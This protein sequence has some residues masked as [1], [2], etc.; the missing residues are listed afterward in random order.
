MKTIGLI[1]GMS[2]ESTK[3]YYELINKRTKDLLGGSHSAKILL[4]SVDFAEI[5]RLTFAGDWETIGDLMEQAAIQLEKGGADFILLCTNTIHMVKDRIE[6]ASPL[7][8]VHIAEAVGEEIVKSS[9]RHIGLLGTRF[10]MEMDF[11]TRTL[12]E[13]FGIRTIVPIKEDRETL[14][15]V[16]YDELVKGEIDNKSRIKCASII[17][18]L[19]RQGA[20]GIILGCTELPL[21]LD[22][23]DASVALFDTTKIHAHKAVDLALQ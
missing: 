13:K 16:I 12:E 3:I 6:K 15:N 21:L 14:H 7:P 9:M 8:F 23:S 2:W 18:T 4:V 1:G 22:S 5:E 19:E 20:N 11:Y 17:S 10:T